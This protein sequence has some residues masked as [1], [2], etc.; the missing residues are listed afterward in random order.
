MHPAGCV[1]VRVTPNV[2]QTLEDARENVEASIALGGGPRRY[3]LLVD[4]TETAPLTSEVRHFYVGG[5]LA[6]SFNAL[7]LLVEASALGTMMGNVFF[8]MLDAVP[9]E[10]GT[11][12]PS[13]VF[14]DEGAAIAWLTAESR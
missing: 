7:G 14:A 5:A 2:R 6:E 12:I 13:R 8:R 10:D 1:I 3:P 4:I 11:K 9:R